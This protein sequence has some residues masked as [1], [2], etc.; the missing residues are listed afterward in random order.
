MVSGLINSVNPQVE[1]HMNSSQF[2]SLQ[3]LK[4]FWEIMKVEML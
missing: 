3:G 1:L 4:S 2:F